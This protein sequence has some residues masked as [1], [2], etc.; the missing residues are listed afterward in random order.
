MWHPGQKQSGSFFQGRRL[1]PVLHDWQSSLLTTRLI[2]HFAPLWHPLFQQPF[3]YNRFL[4]R[5]IVLVNFYFSCNLIFWLVLYI[6]NISPKKQM[7]DWNS[8]L[9][10]ASCVNSEFFCFICTLT[11]CWSICNYYQTTDDI[12]PWSPIYHHLPSYKTS[13]HSVATIPIFGSHCFDLL[14]LFFLKMPK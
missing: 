12:F 14:N 3:K 2:C 7:N 1:N 13:T 6:Q 5:S 4:F 10:P 9:F 11:S 8:T